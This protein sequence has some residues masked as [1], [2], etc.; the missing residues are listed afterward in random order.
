MR[1]ALDTVTLPRPSYEYS[2]GLAARHRESVE[3][4]LGSHSEPL[5]SFVD[6]VKP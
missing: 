1:D 6:S 3:Q 2:L 4:S 5:S